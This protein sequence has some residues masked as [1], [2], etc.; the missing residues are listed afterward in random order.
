VSL[1]A[2]YCCGR[3][4]TTYLFTHAG[5]VGYKPLEQFEVEMDLKKASVIGL[6]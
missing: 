5:R 6:K 2:S 3:R 1:T 4:T